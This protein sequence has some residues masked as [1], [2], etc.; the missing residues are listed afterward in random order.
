M[1]ISS[2]LSFTLTAALAPAVFAG[3]T[4]F[5]V[6]AGSFQVISFVTGGDIESVNGLT[7]GAK[8]DLTVDLDKPANTT[9]KVEID[10]TTFTT[11]IAMRDE[12][13]R[14]DAWLDTTKFPTA[15]FEITKIV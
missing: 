9:G 14:S 4:K 3:T 7:N 12:H 1:K 15:T 11:G 2:L 10:M 5:T 13:F 8:A 6:E